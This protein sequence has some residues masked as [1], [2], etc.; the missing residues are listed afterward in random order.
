M[1]VT[2]HFSKTHF[3]RLTAVRLCSTEKQRKIIE[4]LSVLD[5]QVAAGEVKVP[6]VSMN[7]VPTCGPAKQ[8]D[9][10]KLQE[11]IHRSKRLLVMTGAGCSTESGIPDYRSEGVG[12]Y[13]RSNNRPIQYQDF[14]KHAHIRQRYWARNY[15]GWPKFGYFLP[16]I[17]HKTLAIWEKVGKLHWLVTQNVDALHYK[18]GNIKVTELHGSSHRVMCLGCDF[19]FSRPEFQNLI[20]SFN[21]TWSAESEEMAPDADVQLTEEQIEGFRVPPCPSCGGPLK[22]EITFFGDNV[23]KATVEFV[24]RKVRES[25]ALLMAGTSLQVYSGY[26][27]AAAAKDQHKPVAILNIGPT[28]ADKL[29]DLKIDAKCGDILP[30]IEL[31]VS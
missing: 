12:L 3:I 16:N 20:K 7:F 31:T 19:K 14:V 8:E 5:Q 30:K 4:Y 23:P 24:H 21:P 13:A 18:A 1:S 15:V 25:D 27:F 28:R 26:R 29:A 6:P 10:E 22:P 11:F 9:I 2:L 17:A